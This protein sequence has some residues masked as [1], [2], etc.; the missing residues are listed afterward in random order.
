M[1]MDV[2]RRF[3]S[4]SFFTTISVEP[5]R[6]GSSHMHMPQRRGS[7]HT[8]TE[9]KAQGSTYDRVTVDL[10]CR[11]LPVKVGYLIRDTVLPMYS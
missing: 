2:V 6:R 4:P 8:I 7:P 10:H 3:G 5:Q 11:A 9:Y 1:D